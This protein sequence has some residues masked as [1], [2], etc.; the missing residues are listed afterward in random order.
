[1]YFLRFYKTF[2]NKFGKLCVTM[3]FIASVYVVFE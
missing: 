2:I 1:L 3:F